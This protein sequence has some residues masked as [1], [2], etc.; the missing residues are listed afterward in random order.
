MVV[1]V[2]ISPGYHTSVFGIRIPLF[3][4][5]FRN[6]SKCPFSVYEWAQVTFSFGAKDPVLAAITGIIYAILRSEHG[7]PDLVVTMIVGWWE[8][9]SPLRDAS[10]PWDLCSGLEQGFCCWRCLVSRLLLPV[11]RSFDVCD[12]GMLNPGEKGQR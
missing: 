5:N 11:L 6:L 7:F 8:A 2:R 1:R 3:F 4:S 9:A 12:G 10:W